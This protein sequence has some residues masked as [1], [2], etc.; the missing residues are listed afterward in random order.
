MGNGM[1]DN[2][3]LVIP[4]YDRPWCLVR[5]LDYYRT[6]AP[7]IKIFVA[8]SG[9]GEH[10]EGNS[11]AISLFK[12][13]DI[14]QHWG[15][16]GVEMFRK[17]R[18]AVS[19]VKTQ[20]CVFCG[21][22]DFVTPAG[23]R[24]S[25]SFLDENAD[26]TIAHGYYMNFY[27]DDEK[28]FCRHPCYPYESNV[29]ADAS[30]R[31]MTHFTNYAA[32]TFYAVHRTDFSHMILSEAVKYTVEYRFGELLPSMLAAVH[33]KMKHL[34]VFYAARDNGSEV[35][36]RRPKSIRSFV[37][38]GTYLDKYGPFREC[39]AKHLSQEAS[40]NMQEACEIVDR[41]MDIYYK[42]NNVN[43]E[44]L[45]KLSIYDKLFLP[46]ETMM[47]NFAEELEKPSSKYY[48]DFNDIRNHV[49]KHAGG[50]FNTSGLPDLTAE[51]FR[52]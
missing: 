18:D 42:V 14:S 44:E 6:Y 10:K 21:D 46:G 1:F 20:Y 13:L 22:D 19:Q 41:G 11:R 29:S 25:V 48:D 9:L 3:T 38:D 30:T 26:Y 17:L 39:L 2:V 34:D 36:E 52:R 49:L 23:I 43:R 12:D 45:R 37:E 4:T 47:K 16:Y 51:A 32:A 50:N 24:D 33:G 15:D 5:T 28:R 31:F 27:F 7:D 40:L 8:N 35:V